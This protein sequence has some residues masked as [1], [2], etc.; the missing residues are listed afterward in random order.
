MACNTPSV[1]AAILAGTTARTAAPA[2]SSDAAFTV[3]KISGVGRQSAT[4]CAASAPATAPAVKARPRRANRRAS[5]RRAVANRLERVPSGMP[6][7]RATS[8]RD[9]PS[10]SQSTTGTRYFWGRWLS[11]WSS[12]G[13]QSGSMLSWRASGSGISLTCLSI[14]PRRTATVRAVRAVR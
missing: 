7:C 2:T 11:S 12:T 13:R 4:T 14:A 10:S 3:A 9:R 6:S 1:N 5:I 8:L